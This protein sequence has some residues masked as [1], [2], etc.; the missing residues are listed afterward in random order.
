VADGSGGVAPGSAVV[1]DGSTVVA[2]GAASQALSRG[3]VS[4]SVNPSLNPSAPPGPLPQ[5]STSSAPPG[6]LPQ[7]STS[8]ASTTQGPTQPPSGPLNPSAPKEFTKS[9]IVEIATA[10]QSS[11]SFTDTVNKI[12]ITKNSDNT[13]TIGP[14]P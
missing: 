5:G 8:S 14:I 9:Y 12:K 1:A 13:L 6:P 10:L 2:D 4:V 11:G 3:S 7:G